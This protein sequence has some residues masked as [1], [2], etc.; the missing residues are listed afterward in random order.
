MYEEISSNKRKSILLIFLFIIVIV[1]LGYVFGLLF[2]DPIVG[3][4]IAFFDHQVC[5]TPLSLFP[6]IEPSAARWVTGRRAAHSAR[7]SVIRHTL[8]AWRPAHRFRGSDGASPATPE[9]KRGAGSFAGEEGCR[10]RGRACPGPE[11]WRDRLNRTMRTDRLDRS[12][13]VGAAREPRVPA[14]AGAFW[15]SRS[16]VVAGRLR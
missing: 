6:V 7:T 10:E 9:S 5:L 12:R 8:P 1:V 16:G 4:F 11:A 14:R 2:F 15:A 3:L 13:D